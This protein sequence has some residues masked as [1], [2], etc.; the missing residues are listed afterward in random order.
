M[1]SCAAGTVHPS[2]GGGSASAQG[3]LWGSQ[4]RF[5]TAAVEAPLAGSVRGGARLKERSLQGQD[6]MGCAGGCQVP[7]TCL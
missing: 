1:K 4:G 2:L 7:A 5:V 3:L 6:R